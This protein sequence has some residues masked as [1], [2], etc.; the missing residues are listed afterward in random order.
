MEQFL[1]RKERGEMTKKAECR[2]CSV[3][4]DHS[5]ERWHQC[6]DSAESACGPKSGV[7]LILTSTEVFLSMARKSE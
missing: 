7:R 2:I 6:K 4:S 3:H 1:G 5:V